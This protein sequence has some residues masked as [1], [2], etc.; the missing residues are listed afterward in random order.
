[1]KKVSAI[2]FLTAFITML[3]SPLVEAF[4]GSTMVA[5]RGCCSRHRGVRGCDGSG[6]VICNDNTVS[7]TCRC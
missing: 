5:Q 1:M 3:A 2:L 4:D 6:R 7:P